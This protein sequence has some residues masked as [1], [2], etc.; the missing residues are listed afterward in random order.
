YDYWQASGVS[1]EG[2]RSFYYPRR[3][4][5][6]A[7]CHMPLVESKDPAAKNGRVRSHRFAAANTAVPFVN[8]DRDQVEAVQRFLKD[9]QISVD[10][11]GIV[12][13]EAP[14]GERVAA[15]MD[16]AMGSA[17]T[18]GVGEESLAFGAREA[19]LALAPVVV[20]PFGAAPVL[21]RRGESV[22][23]DVVVRTR[24][25]GH[26]FPGGT[27]DAF[28]VWLDLEVFDEHDRRILHSGSLRE[29]GE[30][31]SAAHRYRSLLLDE[32]GN[33]ID[34][35]NAWAARSVAYVRL[36][37]PGAADTVHYRLVVPDDAGSRLRI[38]AS[39]KY[40]KFAWWNTQWSYAGVRESS[41]GAF[42][43][44]PGHDDGRWVFTG[45][46]SAVSGLMKAIPDIPITEMAV[47]EA[48]M[49]VIGEGTPI[50]DRRA[51]GGSAQRE[52]WNDYG[53]G[54]L[55]QGDL[56]AAESAFLEVTRLEPGYAD[57]WVNVGRARLQGGNLAGAEDV[58]RQALSVDAG[59][60]SAHFFL[61]SVLKLQGQYEESLE[62]LRMAAAR[63]PRDR[64]VL[65][66]I[67]R[68][69]FLMRRFADARIELHKVLRIDPED[70]QA[71][72]N[73]MLIAQGLGDEQS[74]ED[75]RR[76][77]E[78]FKIDESAQ[79]LTGTYRLENPHDNNE[80]Q[81]IH[82]HELTAASNPSA[83]PPRAVDHR[84]ASPGP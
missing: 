24:K 46:T 8:H 78:R 66:Q 55:L 2:A 19:F 29:R 63:Y 84:A 13:G 40:R 10:V 47:N 82:E 57:G 23:I 43:L 38:R 58:L 73:L 30:L 33:P 56:R 51:V 45:D 1:G 62:H 27:V 67:G 50:V 64:V 71:H 39:V 48:V 36:I 16:G 15:S 69:L 4:Q 18:F 81:L 26:F 76:L 35:R 42:A 34:K 61:G 70:L 77:Y 53:I 17:S 80:R 44:G 65:N 21:V 79:A 3:P 41:D 25:V 31:D 37:P 14:R 75:A 9:G 11:F 32:H 20:G 5:S 72:Y 7:D 28:D 54:L 74:A 12:R 59:L 52:R 22:R 6:C 83:A 49:T 60:A 68:V